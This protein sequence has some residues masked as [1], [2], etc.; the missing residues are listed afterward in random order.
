V[1][2]EIL[3]SGSKG[4]AVLLERYA[5]LDC[6]VSYKKLKPYA[7]TLGIVLLTHK[8]RD[9]I[10]VKALAKLASERPTLRVGCPTWMLQEI[11]DHIDPR[12]I[13][14]YEIGKKYDYG[15]WAVSPVQLYHDVP[16][17]GYRI[18]HNNE[19]AFYAT[20][21]AHLNGITAKGYDLYLIEANYGEEEIKEREAKKRAE[22]KFAYE[23]TVPSRHLS[24]EQASAFAL[25]NAGDNS[26]VVFIHQHEDRR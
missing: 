3:S 8:H 16:Q 11:K 17:C 6:G 19:K 2:Y 13:D 15:T 12:Q 22:G 4:N 20:D 10:S 21:T 14:V 26:K 9:H 25:A 23:A 18:Y 5:L 1:T 24:R 7:G